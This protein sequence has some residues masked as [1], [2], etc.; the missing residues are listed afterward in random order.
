MIM[1]KLKSTPGMDG[2]VKKTLLKG[3]QAHVE[4]RLWDGA[5]DGEVGELAGLP[6]MQEELFEAFAGPLPLRRKHIL[7]MG[8]IMDNMY[9]EEI[10]PLRNPKKSEP[11]V[12]VEVQKSIFP[13]DDD[14]PH[15]GDKVVRSDEVWAPCHVCSCLISVSCSC[16][17]KCSLFVFKCLL[18]WGTSACEVL[19][20]C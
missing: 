3:L 10:V 14:K 7:L 16:F 19:L 12:S 8:G 18:F 15:D 1:K 4:R 6:G 11:L 2:Q 17:F 13:P 5:P 9:P 20:M